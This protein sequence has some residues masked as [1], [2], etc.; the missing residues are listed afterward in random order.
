ME[1]QSC[2]DDTY[3]ALVLACGSAVNQDGRSSSLTAP[4]GP[5]Q[6]AV[7]RSTVETSCVPLEQYVQHEMHGTGTSLGDPIEVGAACAVLLSGRAARGPLALSAAK[8]AHG[9]AEAGAGVVGCMHALSSL[10]HGHTSLMTN[11]RTVNPY[12]AETLRVAQ[13]TCVPRQDTAMLGTLSAGAAAC[14]ISSFAFQGTNAHAL[15]GACEEQEA[16]HVMEAQRMNW[17]KQSLWLAP[18][19]HPLLRTF[20]LGAAGKAA[21]AFRSRTST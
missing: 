21:R 3:P 2:G 9:H 18:R 14:G 10:T 20:Q 15:L 6:Q 12:V 17:S 1:L 8:I 4:N 11:L 7:I 16:S 5:S 19:A 13:M